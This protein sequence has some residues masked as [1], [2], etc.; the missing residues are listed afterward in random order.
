MCRF[1]Y[2]S[3]WAAGISCAQRSQ[4]L[5][6]DR[7][8]IAAPEFNR[9]ETLELNANQQDQSVSTGGQAIQSGRDTVINH[10]M[11]LTQ[12]AEVLREIQ[13]ITQSFTAEAMERVHARFAEFEEEV[14]KKFMDPTKTNAASFRDPDFQL[15]LADAQK[16]YA[17]SGNEAVRETLADIIARRSMAETASRVALT[18]NDAAERAPRLTKSEFAALSLSYIVRYTLST[19][20]NSA[21]SM[22]DYINDILVP[23]AKQVSREQASFWHIEAQSCGSIGIGEIDISDVF[24]KNY[25]GV[26]GQGLD[27]TLL[28]SQFS[29][30]AGPTLESILCYSMRDA[31]LVQPRA[32]TLEIFLDVYRDHGFSSE[33]LKHIWNQYIATIPND[34][35]DILRPLSPDIDLLF[36]VWRTTPLK[37]L[38]LNSVGIAIGHANAVR[39]V[40]FDSPL[41]NWIK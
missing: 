12:M 37:S 29:S 26:L 9:G 1:V 31:N 25:P 32:M 40:G 20:V 39:V 7:I 28:Q 27:L 10:G 16:A 18:L 2:L 3:G 4:K 24:R 30:R 38:Q 21:K 5:F 13:N 23:L 36:E 41:E 22:A 8:L 14:L 34:F 33:E 6:R 11:S 15:M 17:R 19:L 35:G